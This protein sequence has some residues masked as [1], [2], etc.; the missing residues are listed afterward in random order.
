[1]KGQINIQDQFL[2]KI[3]KEKL[4]TA[5]ELT[6]GDKVHGYI[7][8]FDNFSI[9]VNGGGEKLVYKHA[10]SMIYPMEKKVANNKNK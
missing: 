2:N 10:I 6:N 1:M 7:V 9:L 3:R 5:F 8:S 4:W